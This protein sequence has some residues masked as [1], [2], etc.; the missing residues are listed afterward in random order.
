MNSPLGIPPLFGLSA[1]MTAK[2]NRK[3]FWRIFFQIDPSHPAMGLNFS[4]K[5]DLPK[6][7]EGVTG[8]T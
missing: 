5:N 1:Q 7:G 6:I 3:L 4:K 8:F 2:L